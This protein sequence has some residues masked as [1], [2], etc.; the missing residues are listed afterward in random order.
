[1]LEEW[2]KRNRVPFFV[3]GTADRFI[4]LSTQTKELLLRLNDYNVS[5]ESFTTNYQNETLN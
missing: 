4:E 5:K 2:N 3:E 1:M